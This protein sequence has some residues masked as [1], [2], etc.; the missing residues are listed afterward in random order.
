MPNADDPANGVV[1]EAVRTDPET[2]LYII[3]GPAEVVMS[4]ARPEQEFACK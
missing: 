4:F 1:D 2:P 3:I